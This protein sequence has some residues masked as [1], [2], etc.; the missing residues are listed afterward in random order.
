[1]ADSISNLL[2][3]LQPE[4]LVLG[5]NVLR[6]RGLYPEHQTADDTEAVRAAYLDGGA[7]EGHAPPDP[8]P[9]LERVLGWDARFVAGPPGGPQM[10][11]GLATSLLEH[12]D[13][14]RP[15][16]A[17]LGKDGV[18]LALLRIA[19]DLDPDTRGAE[20]GWE[21][22]PHQRLERLLRETGVPVGILIS[23]GRL[24]LIY[25]PEGETSGWMTWPLAPIARNEG[26]ELLAGLK[27]A[28]GRARWWGA[29][30]GSLSALAAE[31][32]ATQ[33]DV[34][35]QLAVQVLGALHELMRGIHPRRPRPHRRFGPHPT[36]APLRG[37][38]GDTDAARVSA[39]C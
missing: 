39:L 36:A 18:A 15:D 33:N 32:R 19:P 28:I 9:L 11:D 27:L 31:S 35:A 17:L 2:G 7:E 3:L 8:W 26:R 20:D 5:G 25:A 4:G 16:M 29:P 22:S 23:G 30:E 6:A 38:A 14:L 13:V 21:A 1:M 37:S 12:G 10:P 34:S 24:R